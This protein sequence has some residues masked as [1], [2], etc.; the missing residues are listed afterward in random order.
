[1]CDVTLLALLSETSDLCVTC[2][3]FS[4]TLCSLLEGLFASEGDLLL[5][6]HCVEVRGKEEAQEGEE[7][8]CGSQKESCE[9]AEQMRREVANGNII[10]LTPELRLQVI[11]S[12]SQGRRTS[13]PTN[14]QH[15]PNAR[16]DHCDNL[17]DRPGTIYHGHRSQVNDIGHDGDRQGTGDDL[18]NLIFRSRL[19]RK[20]SLQSARHDVSQRST[21]SGAINE[22]LDGSIVDAEGG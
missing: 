5:L 2:I 18:C 9:L 7:W 17:I 6:C 1:M 20:G 14:L 15:P 3:L 8:F 16:L 21:N 19:S 4:L 12:K 22:H 11:L 10:P 13:Q